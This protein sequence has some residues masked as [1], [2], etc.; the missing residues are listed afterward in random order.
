MDIVI[1]G[2]HGKIAM[3][4]HPLLTARGHRVRGLVRNPDHVPELEALGVE[5]VVCDM[6]AEPDIAA[7]VGSADAVVFAAGAGPGSGEARKWSMDRDGAL[8]LIDAARANGIERYIMISAMHTRTPRGNDVFK[9][10]LRAKAEADDALTDSGLAYTIVRPGSLTDD[11]GTGCV[12]LAE[13][14]PKGEI[15]R[16]DVAAVIAEVLDR[17]ETARRAFD[18]TGGTEPIPD[19]LRLL[20]A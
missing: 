9:A 12:A 15:P 6:E 8:K 7:P 2:A 10:Y 13:S 5:G 4:L 19:A 18:L 14:L 16:A 11:P 1:A 3:L 20:T 17:P